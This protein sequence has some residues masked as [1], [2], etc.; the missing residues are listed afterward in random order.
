[1]DNYLWLKPLLI[2]YQEILFL[3]LVD[4]I[5]RGDRSYQS[6]SEDRHPETAFF[7]LK[8]ETLN[9]NYLIINDE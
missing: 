7:P 9:Q 3:L 2:E 1:M 5:W 4:W 6:R 8:E